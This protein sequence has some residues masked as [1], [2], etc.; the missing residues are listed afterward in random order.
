MASEGRSNTSILN[1]FFRIA[2]IL[3]EI[4]LL[5]YVL[6]IPIPGRVM[7]AAMVVECTSKSAY[8][9]MDQDTAKG[10]PGCR[11]VKLPG[12]EQLPAF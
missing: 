8:R 6:G 2:I 7:W 3:E 5:V 10:R 9:L 12:W 11:S 4:A 1:I